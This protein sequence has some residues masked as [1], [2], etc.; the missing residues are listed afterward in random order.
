MNH[1]NPDIPK[2]VELAKEGDKDAFG[3]I[4]DHFFKMIYRYVFFR[5]D[6]A[7]VE[8]IV[9]NIFIKSWVNLEKYKDTGASFKAWLFRIAHNAVVDHHRRHRKI[10]PIEEHIPDEKTESAPQKQTQRNMQAEKVREAIS[11]LEGAYRQVIT[12]KFLSGLSNSEVAEIM[13]QKEGNIRVLQYRALKKL[14]EILKNNVI[15]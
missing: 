9:E 5:T 12:L 13:G 4:Y 3:I 1:E 8:D 15:L 6:S 14:E 2:L 7:E 10:M 11:H